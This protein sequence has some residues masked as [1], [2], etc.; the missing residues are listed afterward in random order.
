MVDDL[1][2]R[3][4]GAAVTPLLRKPF[5]EVD[6]TYEKNGPARE[7]TALPG[8]VVSGSF[9]PLAGSSAAGRLPP[10][11]PRKEANPGCPPVRCRDGAA[12]I[13]RL[14]TDA[15]YPDL[16]SFHGGIDFLH[17]IFRSGVGAGD[18]A[19]AYLVGPF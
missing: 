9:L 8:P 12:C 5:R 17:V 7:S 18:H 15:P 3:L 19:Q 14:F 2:E 10:P 13:K 1:A 16:G 6:A 4:A 11:P